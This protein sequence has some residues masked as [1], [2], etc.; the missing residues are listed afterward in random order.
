MSGTKL[1]ARKAALI[2]VTRHGFD[3]YKNIGAKGGR[4]GHTGGM[5][6]NRKVASI[7]GKKGGTVSR[8]TGSKNVGVK[9]KRS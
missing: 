3:F 9:H 8:R 4:N 7:G 1:G 6:T 5:C 2:N